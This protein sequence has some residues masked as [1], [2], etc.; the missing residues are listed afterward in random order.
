MFSFTNGLQGV[1]RGTRSR[2]GT[3]GNGQRTDNQS[4]ESWQVQGMGEAPWDL[5]VARGTTG[6]GDPRSYSFRKGVGQQGTEM[7]FGFAPPVFSKSGPRSGYCFKRSGNR[8][9]RY[10]G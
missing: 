10:M 9:P 4:L 8:S 3:Q 1:G 2:S 5:S 6:V 7:G